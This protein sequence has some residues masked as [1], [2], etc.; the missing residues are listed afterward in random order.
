MLI[1]YRV[2]GC[3]SIHLSDTSV[4]IFSKIDTIFN[5][6]KVLIHKKEYKNSDFQKSMFLMPSAHQA[7]RSNWTELCS[8]ISWC[9]GVCN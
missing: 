9:A 7:K 3:S 2:C 4:E 8:R 5:L 6:L 1:A